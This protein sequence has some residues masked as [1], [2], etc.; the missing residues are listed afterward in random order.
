[1]FGVLGF[2]FL[3]GAAG[4]S[5]NCSLP[6]NC[7]HSQW[8]VPCSDASDESTCKASGGQWCPSPSPTPLTPSPPVV[9]V[10]HE[11]L[12]CINDYSS[13]WPKCDPSQAKTNRGPSGYEFGFY[14]TEQWA[15]ALNSMLTAVG[16]C[17]DAV[18]IKKLLG[19]TTYETGY[20]S[21]VYQ[22]ADG[23]AGLIH[24]IPA[25][26]Q[27]NAGDMDK[28]FSDQGFADKAKAMG[29]SFFQSSQYG[30]LSVAAWYK[31][32]NRVVADDCGVDLFDASYDKQTECILGSRMDRSETL[33]VATD[34]F[35]KFMVAA[36]ETVMV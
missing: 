11:V 19:E 8:K 6:D 35:S 4:A 28:L 2:G 27:L 12:T 21:T 13:Y 25:N 29:K 15:D 31:L 20:F 10:K 26:W 22:P 32:T 24:M 16:K 1:M 9:C 5:C 30:W 36:N 34:C 7:Y 3:A 18:A 23:G 17:D 33:K 14:C